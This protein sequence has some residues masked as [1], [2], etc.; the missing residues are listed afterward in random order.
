[1][2]ADVV[3]KGGNLLLNIGPGPDGRWHDV[4]YDRLE[5][6]GDWLRVNGEAIYGTRAMAPYTQGKYRLTRAMDGAVYAIYQVAEKGLW[7]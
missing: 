2:L 1:M 3:A 7:R 4:A 5:D 6:L